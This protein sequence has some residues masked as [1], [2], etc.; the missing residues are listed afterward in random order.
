LF[1][2]VQPNDIDYHAGMKVSDLIVDGALDADRIF[3][4]LPL[5]LALKVIGYP[6]TRFCSIPDKLMWRYTPDGIFTSK[7]AH[8]ALLDN[9]IDGSS[10]CL[11]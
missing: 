2:E 6:L 3:S 9:E 8:K 4:M 7:T 5:D 11:G 10:C 1:G